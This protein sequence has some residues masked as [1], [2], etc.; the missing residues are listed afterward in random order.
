[1]IRHVP[2][3]LMLAGLAA[4]TIAAIIGPVRA[5]EKDRTA[6]WQLMVCADGRDCELRGRVLSGPTACSLDL[7]SASNV[8]PSGSRLSCVKVSKEAAR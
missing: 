7:A 6:G 3:L 1:M 5:A 2:W 4:F 8:V